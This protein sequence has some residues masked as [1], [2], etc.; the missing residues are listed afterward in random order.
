MYQK[1]YT[2]EE[3]IKGF[4]KEISKELLKDEAH[5]WRAL[6]GIEL[7]HKEPIRSEQERI[8]N[9]WQEM[10]D[11]NKKVSD[12]KSLE[13]FGMTN[14]E[15]NIKIIRDVM[16]KKF[17]F[18]IISFIILIAVVLGG[19]ILFINRKLAINNLVQE[20]TFSSQCGEYAKNEVVVG[21]QIVK[22][23]ISDTNCKR[24][25]GLSGRK[26]LSDNEGMLFVFEKEGNYG[27]WMKDMNFPID[28]IWVG[29]DLS[30]V[31]DEKKLDPSTYP[32]IFGGKFLAKYV[33]E[34]PAGF[35]DKYN[36]SVGNKISISKK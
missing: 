2:K 16:I 17:S 25:L 22:M 14:E 29:A 21:G 31:G 3:I 20:K 10:S 9:N 12:K 26:S 23:D 32:N 28:I 5:L 1:P 30:V 36:L 4:P 35:S 27:F 33:L 18:W 6:T 24:E 19:W 7:I 15:H 11:E 34:L 13:L 8:W